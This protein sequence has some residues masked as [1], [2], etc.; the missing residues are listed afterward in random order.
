ML[1]VWGKQVKNGKV[2]ASETF[3]SDKD[4]MSAALLESL[5][6][7]GHEFDMETPMWSSLHT[8]QLGTHHKAVFKQDDFVDHINFDRFELQLLEQD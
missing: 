6:H 7:F 2:I 1:R 3:K 8:K 4:D 5:E